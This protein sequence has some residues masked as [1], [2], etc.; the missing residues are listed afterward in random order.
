MMTMYNECYLPEHQ[1]NPLIE[2][3]PSVVD[4]PE[5]I[6]RLRS[7][8]VCKAAERDLPAYIRTKFLHRLEQFTEPTYEYLNCFRIIEDMI[9]ESY[10]PKN[11]LKNTTQHWLH[12]D[13]IEKT[14]H[15]PSHGL[16]VSRA[17]SMA[18]VGDGGAGKTWMLE[19]ILRYFPQ[20]INHTEYKGTPLHLTQIVWMKVNCTE[21]ANVSALLILIL[22]ELDRLTGSD[23]ARRAVTSRDR[24]AQA[25]LAIS[26][27]LKSIYLGVL[28]ID[29]IQHLQFANRKLK[30]LFIQFLLNTLGRAGVPIVF[31]GDPRVTDFL[32]TGLPVSRRVETGGTIYMRGYE[33]H[34]WDLFV[35]NLW[36]Y[37][38]TNPKTP[39]SEELTN[40][41]WNLSTGLPDFAIKI[42]K[43]AQKLLIGQSDESISPAVLRQAYSEK[44]AL[45]HAEL[46]KRRQA[47]KIAAG[48]NNNSHLEGS[49][50]SA[51]FDGSTE[52][53]REAIPAKKVKTKIFD[54]N[55]VQHEEFKTQ[56]A[57]LNSRSFLPPSSI[58]LDILRKAAQFSD[59]MESLMNSK[60]LLRH[61]DLLRT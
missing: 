28:V 54:V 38:W 30:E 59:P 29:E 61:S 22:E 50:K 49:A 14:K 37:Q 5:V 12:H 33:N 52:A 21:N 40:C 45:S 32:T 16:F 46:E 17:V 27:K 60:I 31:A 25:S 2:A 6:M 10:I 35:E 43:H 3:L 56:I 57:E 4:N 8:Q 24:V 44:C 19:A 51:S 53:L 11:P 48:V 13:E 20:V 23:D 1:G 15:V 34:D 9:T 55:R 7:K 18:I 58:K 41:L 26:R 39:R 36:R 47:I 42:F